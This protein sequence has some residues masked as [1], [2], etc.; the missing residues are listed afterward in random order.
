[1]ERFHFDALGSQSQRVTVPGPN[2]TVACDAGVTPAGATNDSDASRNS[3]SL[4]GADALVARAR[5]SAV[6]A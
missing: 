5:S 4:G 1:M 2:T 6:L 3:K